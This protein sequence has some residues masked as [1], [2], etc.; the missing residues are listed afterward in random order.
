MPD[1]PV[2]SKMLSD[3]NQIVI[4]WTPPGSNGG[5]SVL[6]YQLWMRQVTSPVSS[7]EL[8]Y[9]AP[10]DAITQTYLIST[11]HSLGLQN[12]VYEFVGYAINAVGKS[13][14][15]STL[16]TKAELPTAPAKCIVSGAGIVATTSRTN[17]AVTVQTVDQNGNNKTAGGDV[18]FLHATD[19]CRTNGV[20]FNC[21]RVLTTD[22][23]YVNNMFAAPF[24]VQMRDNGDGTY[25]ANYSAPKKGYVTIILYWMRNSGVYAEYYAGMY[26][27][28]NHIAARVDPGLSMNWGSGIIV[29]AYYDYVSVRW[30]GKIRAPTSE[31]YT[32]SFSSDDRFWVLIN[33]TNIGNSFTTWKGPV[34]GGYSPTLTKGEFYDVVVEWD[35]IWGVAYFILY[36][37][38]PA[39]SGRV[40]PSQFYWYP[41][42]LGVGTYEVKVY[43]SVLP[44][45]CYATGEGLRTA[46]IDHP[47]TIEIFSVYEDGQ[48]PTVQTEQYYVTMVE[49]V[50]ETTSR[51]FPVSYVSRNNYEFTYTVDTVGT[52][53]LS[54]WLLGQHIRDSP[55]A[56]KVTEPP[57]H[58]YC[59]HCNETTEYDCKSCKPGVSFS[60]EGVPGLCVDG[61]Y[62]TAQYSE[63]VGYYRAAD[64]LSCKRIWRATNSRVQ[65][66]LSHL[67]RGHRKRLF[68]LQGCRTRPVPGLLRQEVRSTLLCLRWDLLWCQAYI[69]CG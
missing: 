60:V 35:E 34:V 12:V 45:L 63:L 1:P 55:F 23:H 9:N 29:G 56:V 24:E 21:T 54:I 5:M 44:S 6:G 19:V 47:R 20:D 16:M 53:T 46:L 30:V 51:S 67:H 40:I 15:S 68:A 7:F 59:A 33:S 22:P 37:S 13:V 18:I 31:K 14:A 27:E 32:F 26:L 3:T 2:L 4:T 8:I 17:T 49:P 69:T 65:L 52:Y 64:G 66:C 36:W 62:N 10:T 39:I 28:G 42:Y 41:T 48:L 58:A 43:A 38:T 11:F 25:S 50:P 57:C 61:C